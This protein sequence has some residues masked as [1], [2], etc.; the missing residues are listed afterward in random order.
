MF[1]CTHHS[2]KD[3]PQYVHVDVPSDYLRYWIFYYT[4]YSNM[5]VPQYVTPVKKRK[6]GGDFTILK[7]SKKHY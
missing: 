6:K 7:R 5:Y 4:Q 3:A 1:Y 2:N